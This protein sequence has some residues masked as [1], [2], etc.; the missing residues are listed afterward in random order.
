MFFSMVQ[1]SKFGGEKL[2]PFWFIT[3]SILSLSLRPSFDLLTEASNLTWENRTN[4][5]NIN[6]IVNKFLTNLF[7]LFLMFELSFYQILSS[8]LNLSRYY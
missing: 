1:F 5:L 4:D 2:S 7:E 3:K 6:S 8:D